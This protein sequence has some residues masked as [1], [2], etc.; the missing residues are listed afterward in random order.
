MLR[1]GNSRPITEN[2]DDVSEHHGVSEEKPAVEI[3][4]ALKDRY[5][6]RQLRVALGLPRQPKQR[7]LCDGGSWPRTVDPPCHSCTAHGTYSWEAW[8]TTGN[9]MK[10][11]SRTQQ[12]QKARGHLT[13]PSGRLSYFH[14]N[15]RII[16][17]FTRKQLL[18]TLDQINPVFF[19]FMINSY[20]ITQI[21]TQSSRSAISHP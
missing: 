1:W 11:R 19:S 10:G 13:R 16:I 20:E 2:S 3:F 18:L 4:G 6:D 9:D 8:Q 21:L 5:G 14:E 17:M 15:R 7:T 12:Q